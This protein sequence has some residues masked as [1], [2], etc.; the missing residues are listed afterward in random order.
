ATAVPGAE[1][2]RSGE[3]RTERASRP[4]TPRTPLRSVTTPVTPRDGCLTSC[5]AEE[6]GGVLH[7]ERAGQADGRAPGR[8]GDGQWERLE[9]GGALLQAAGLELRVPDDGE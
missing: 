9:E 8:G 3:L 7:P 1:G 6:G 5:A 2:R 4:S